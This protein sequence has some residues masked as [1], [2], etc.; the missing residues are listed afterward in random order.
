MSRL[1]ISAAATVH[2]DAWFTALDR[3]ELALW[4]LPPAVAQY[5]YM[6]EAL[7]REPLLQQIRRLEHEA[8]LL[9]LAAFSPRERAAQYR[10]RLDQHFRLEEQRFF[11]AEGG[12]NDFTNNGTSER[13]TLLRAA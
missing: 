1:S 9:Y 3:G 8:D 2:L 5:V 4:Q 10:A 12:H 7:G 11:A 13:G 6:G